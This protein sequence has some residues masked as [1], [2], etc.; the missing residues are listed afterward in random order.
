[1]KKKIFAFTFILF[2]LTVS[3]CFADFSG[4]MA[5]GTALSFQVKSSGT[6]ENQG[7]PNLYDRAK[8]FFENKKY[9]SAY[10]LFLQSRY[11][12][13]E[14]MAQKCIRRW[15]QNG[16]IFRDASEWLRDTQLT[17]KVDQPE[18]TAVLIRVYKIDNKTKAEKPVSYV[19]IGGSD[20]VT[21][22]LPGNTTYRIRDGVGSDWFG[23]E[24]S[25][26][27]DGAYETMT[28]GDY[29]EEE[30]TIHLEQRLD[31]MI[32][33]NVENVIGERVGSEDLDWQGFTK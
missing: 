1:M 17:F 25:F 24:D 15:P 30:T 13:W 16:E 23:P 4:K 19:F 21:I 6:S 7:D 20:A 33:I 31:Y 26:G 8:T 12:D 14:K 28:F 18:D 2:L 29:E 32:T 9:Y 11:N 5:Q 22:S 10:K 3:I 27:E